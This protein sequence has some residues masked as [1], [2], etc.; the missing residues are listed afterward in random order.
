MGQGYQ[1]ICKKCQHQYGVCPG[2]GFSYPQDYQDFLKEIADGKYGE[3]RKHLVAETP[4]VAVNAETIVFICNDCG[5][6]EE[7]QNPTLYAPH[8]PESIS[9]ELFGS[10]TVKEWGFVPY[11]TPGKLRKNYHLLESYR[12]LCSKCGGKMHKATKKELKTLSC[13]KCGE[14][15]ISEDIMMW[16]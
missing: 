15:N 6:W 5:Y 14:P 3:K 2:M 12:R 9:K 1:Y 16:D 4:Y 7:G 11:V 8:D 13:P 10:K